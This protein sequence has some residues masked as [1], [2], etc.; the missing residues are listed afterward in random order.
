MKPQRFEIGQ[1]VAV[2]FGE[3]SQFNTAR[4]VK[5]PRA[6]EIYHVESYHW[7]RDLLKIYP[8]FNV[9]KNNWYIGLAELNGLYWEL[10][11]DP[12]ITDS[13]LESLLNSVPETQTVEV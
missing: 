1:A 2:K 4:G 7:G 11:F 10:S 6:G 13:E 3:I 8:Q 9:D 12:V 5:T